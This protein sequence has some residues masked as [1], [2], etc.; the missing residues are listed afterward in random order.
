MKLEHLYATCVNSKHTDLEDRKEY[1]VVE[2]KSFD[3]FGDSLFF[4]LE[5]GLA[6]ASIHFSVTYFK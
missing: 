6:Y 4:V 2:M 3:G 5:N 1:R